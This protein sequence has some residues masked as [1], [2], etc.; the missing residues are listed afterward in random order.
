MSEKKQKTIIT[1]AN[2]TYAHSF[3]DN[4]LIHKE[5]CDRVF[6][7]IAR[8]IARVNE[9]SPES[10]NRQM[11]YYNT[12]SVFGERGTGKTSFLHSVI[13]RLEQDYANDVV[14]LGFIDPTII[15]E[16]EH[17]FLL[18]ISL[19]N[20]L[21]EE[22]LKSEDCKLHTKSYSQRNQ[23]Q[24]QLMLMAKGIP[25]LDKVGESRQTSKWQSHEF[26]MEKG[27]D[28]V[29]SAYTLESEFKKLV[30]LALDILGKKCFV[31]ALDDIDV[32]MK[33]GWDVLEM[34]RKYI[35][36]PQIIT[37]LSGN[38]KLYSL[39]V[40][41]HQWE[42]LE[43][44]NEYEP[45]K[46]YLKT[47]NELEGQ[48]LL[49]VLKTENRIHLKSIF[50][51]IELLGAEYE[52]AQANGTTKSIIQAY[53]DIFAGLGIKGLAQ[54]KV[55]VTYMLGL[56]VRSQIQFLLNNLDVEKQGMDSV[57]AFLSRLYAANVD[58]NLAVNN[59]Q[60]LALIIQRYLENQESTPD[61][62]Q[63]MPNYPHEDVNACLTAFTILFAKEVRKSNFLVFDY[64]V[65]IG[66]VRNLLLGMDRYYIRDEFY[67]H[68]GLKQMMS[69]KN[70]VGLS[71]GFCLV[72]E[73]QLA[74]HIA[75]LALAG[76]N[77]QNKSWSQGHI[78]FEVEE[79]ANR[80]QGVI[81]YL[82]ISVMKYTDKNESR[83]FYSFYNL[84]AV[85]AEVLKASAN[86]KQEEAVKTLLMNLQLIRTYPAWKQE[87]DMQNKFVEESDDFAFDEEIMLKKWDGDTTLDTLT[88]E[89]VKW[90]NEYHE[91]IPPY[92]LG[93]II[94]RLYYTL[95]KI[96]EV[97]LGMQM[98]RSVMAF[99]NACLIE[100]CS[101]YYIKKDDFESIEKLNLSNV[102][103]DDKVFLN[104]LSFVLRNK[105]RNNIRLTEWMMKCPLLWAFTLPEVLKNVSETVKKESGAASDISHPYDFGYDDNLNVH[106]ILRFVKIKN[107]I[108][109]T[110][111]VFS[112]SKG[113]ISKTIEILKAFG[114]SI[115]SLLDGSRP[116]DTVVEE[117][118]K[119]GIFGNKINKS[120]ITAFRKN[121]PKKKVEIEIMTGEE[122]AEQMEKEKNANETSADVT[123]EK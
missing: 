95:Q 30:K 122:F 56:S 73:S 50:E 39:N 85:I 42:Q 58:I 64:L 44:N 97:D 92:L 70:S 120:Q 69:L 29:Y 63:L 60:M 111:P 62:Y 81:A 105:A 106:K 61:L 98:H 96:Q 26:I 13:H 53:N 18:V 107:A 71:I 5:E 94:T 3:N 93:K 14:I 108:D 4:E 47:V 49:K 38:L 17:V 7:L 123:P 22:K 28:M 75:L 52:I 21:V 67:N 101:E 8:Q 1:L 2:S 48:Y 34:L 87:G 74:S 76:K 121:Y 104:N 119:S 65:R 114:Y 54:Q 91:S 109:K 82:P 32:D 46:D 43:K 68:V 16:K 117:L 27:L 103:T 59:A 19:I 11:H 31:L 33:K 77:K 83:V 23:W 90:S 116:T 37:I 86:D 66:Y 12:I 112:A 72:Y 118:D 80:A 40:R 78:D 102:I 55:Y 25:T 41:K 6:E 79:R 110:K 115:E 51:A 89:V 15:E 45:G 10:G 84:L 100:E 35:T 36:T 113:S 57:E 9:S 99:L 24:H 20:K 88:R